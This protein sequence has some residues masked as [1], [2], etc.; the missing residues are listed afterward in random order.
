LDDPVTQEGRCRRITW[1]DALAYGC[2][3]LVTGVVLWVIGT[4]LLIVLFGI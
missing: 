2:A 4:I 3:L 1:S